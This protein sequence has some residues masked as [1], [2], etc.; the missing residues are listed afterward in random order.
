MAQM[1]ILQWTE[2][3]GSLVDSLIVIVPSQQEHWVTPFCPPQE[4][5][6][7]ETTRGKSTIVKPGEFQ[8]GGWQDEATH[9]IRLVPAPQ[10]SVVFS[11]PTTTFSSS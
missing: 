10:T 5:Q 7:I 2:K 8:I 6:K 11:F 4:S 3:A 1:K 9:L